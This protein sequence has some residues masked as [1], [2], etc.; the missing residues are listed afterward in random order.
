MTNLSA[1]PP[2]A[3]L[4]LFLVGSAARAEEQPQILPT[5]DVDITYDVT[6]PP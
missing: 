5:R 4:A 3:V 1:L 6:R 2:T